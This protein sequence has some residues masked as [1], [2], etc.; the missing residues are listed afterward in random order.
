M[1]C[2]GYDGKT[3][4]RPTSGG[5]A[6]SHVRKYNFS[7]MRL[8]KPDGSLVLDRSIRDGDLARGIH[9]L[10]VK[11]NRAMQIPLLALSITSLTM[12]SQHERFFP[13]TSCRR[14]RGIQ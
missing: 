10:L 6:Q 14:S 9:A 8:R 11:V 3:S 4:P 2:H 12:T 7:H 13:A 5:F 1:Q